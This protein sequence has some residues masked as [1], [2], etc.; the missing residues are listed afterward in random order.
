MGLWVSVYAFFKVAM[1]KRQDNKSAEEDAFLATCKLY[2]GKTNVKVLDTQVQKVTHGKHFT[3]VDT[4]MEL[5]IHVAEQDR[6]R[7]YSK[8][9]EIAKD[10]CLPVGIAFFACEA[11]DYETGKMVVGG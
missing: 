10:I 3:V 2:T 11:F 5:E 6:T 7:A 9:E 8:A 4:G 1:E